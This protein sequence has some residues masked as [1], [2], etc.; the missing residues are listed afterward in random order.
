MEL[1]FVMSIVDRAR[2]KEMSAIHKELDISLAWSNLGEGTATS[3]HLLLYDLEQSEKAI[4]S[5]VVT[6]TTLKKLLVAAKLRLFIDIPGNGIM[7]A[8]PIKS[9]VGGN[10]LTY[11][12]DGQTT[13]GGVPNMNFEHE[14]LVVVL[15]EG[16]TD[17]V[18][19]AARGAGAAGGTVFHAKGTGGR[20]S[21]RFFG[22]SLAEG[23]DI[24]YILAPA[25]TKASIMQAINSDCGPET[26]IG[27]ICF[28]VPVSHV[29]GLRKLED[30]S[31]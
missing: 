26:E 18:M 28:S 10:Q 20:Q 9:V 19:D 12:T 14:L 21:E 6:G 30:I 22:V 23:K 13:G 27:A 5:A 15:N 24:I 1:Y 4:F 29:A 11:I 2:S 3:E 7:M 25:T 8:I 17:A 31:R 16:Y